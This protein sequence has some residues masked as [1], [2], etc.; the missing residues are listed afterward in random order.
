MYN[1]SGITYRLWSP[2]SFLFII[3]LASLLISIFM[4]KP[5]RFFDFK[6]ELAS[7]AFGVVLCVVYLSRILFPGV[8]SYTGEFVESHRTS[9]VAPPLPFTSKYVFWNGEGKKKVVYLDTFSK[10]EIIPDGLEP[11]EEYTVYFD[12]FTKVIVRVEQNID[13]EQ[14]SEE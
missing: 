8:S 10:K 12:E 3:P 7:A 2:C 1:F 4:K 5:I 9:R 13:G 6:I 14:D 11:G